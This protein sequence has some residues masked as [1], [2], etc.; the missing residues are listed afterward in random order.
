MHW[1][2]SDMILCKK[3]EAKAAGFYVKINVIN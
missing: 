3:T 1:M 2:S